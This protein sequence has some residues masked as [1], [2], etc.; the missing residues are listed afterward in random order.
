MSRVPLLAVTLVVSLAALP[1][2]ASTRLTYTINN[3]PVPV[4]WPASA[5]PIPYEVDSRVMSALPNAT[6]VIDRA[7]AAWAGVPDAQVSFKQTGIASG[8]QAGKDGVNTISLADDLFKGQNAIAM[9]TNWYDTKGELTEADIQIDTTMV[10]SDYNIQQALTH[11][12]G[13]FLGLDHSAV[14]SSI[15]YPYVPKGTD[16][17]SLDSDDRIAIAAIYPKIDSNS[18]GG[19]LQGKVIGDNGGLFAAQVVAMNDHGE[20][21]ATALT[22]ANGAFSIESLPPGDYRVYAEPLDGPVSGQNLAGVYRTAQITSFPTH[23]CD[24]ATVHVDSGR[25][26]GNLIVNSSGAPIQLNPRWIGVTTPGNDQFKLSSNALTVQPGQSV[27][28][29][30]AGDGIT[31]GMTTFDAMNPGFHRTSDFHYAGNYVYAT[32]AI[33]PDASPGSVVILARS[34]TS[35]ATLTGGLLIPAV[36]GRVR[37]VRR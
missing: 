34:G 7:F 26:Y 33:A 2:A 15:M 10:T 25:V 32:F 22:D 21:V 18:A 30:V 27:N 14:L 19:M 20:P 13:H 37:V 9:T 12:V 31:S 24:T 28:I 6:M 8:L 3:N 1:L 5:F 11:E 17:P 23:F 16:A 35:E 36:P 29:A 4:A